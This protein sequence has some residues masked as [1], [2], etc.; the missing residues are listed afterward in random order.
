MKLKLQVANLLIL[1]PLTSRI[2]YFKLSVMVLFYPHSNL[3]YNQTKKPFGF[4]FLHFFTKFWN[5]NL[6]ILI[7]DDFKNKVVH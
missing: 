1:L 7:W 5:I 6:Y 3:S 4:F 2:L